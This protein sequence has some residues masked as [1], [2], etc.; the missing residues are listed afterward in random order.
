MLETT[1]PRNSALQRARVAVRDRI[2]ERTQQ[3]TLR[4]LGDR[5]LRDAD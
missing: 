4:A 2:P 1:S 5:G 3:A